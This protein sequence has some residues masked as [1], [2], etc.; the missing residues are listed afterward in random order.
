MEENNCLVFFRFR[1]KEI[2][3]KDREYFLL[4]VKKFSATLTIKIM[5]NKCM[6]S[7]LVSEVTIV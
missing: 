7:A 2:K 1:F 4:L 6:K 5:D 3:E